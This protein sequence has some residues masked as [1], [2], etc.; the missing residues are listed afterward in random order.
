LAMWEKAK[1]APARDRAGLKM[2][3]LTIRA[4]T[5]LHTGPRYK[6]IKLIF[7]N[8]YFHL[9]SF[10][11]VKFKGARERPRDEMMRIGVDLGGTKIE[12]IALGDQGETLARRRTAT[13][14]DDS[15]PKGR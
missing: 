9:T 10:I 4:R 8:F 5:L 1:F 12:A 13:P 6:G 3:T 11:A 14:R 2:P 15:Q 7:G